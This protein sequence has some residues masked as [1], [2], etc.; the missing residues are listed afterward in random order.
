MEN[1]ESTRFLDWSDFR[2]DFKK[3]FCPANVDSVAINRLESTGYF[4]KTRSLEEYVDEF[5]DLITD[6]G[7]TDPKT[8]VVKFRRGLNAQI[9]NSIATMASGRPS[10]TDPTGWYRMAWTIDES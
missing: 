10:N 2:D 4:Q 1:P 5:Q 7:Y 9:Q 3:E 8:I 6:S